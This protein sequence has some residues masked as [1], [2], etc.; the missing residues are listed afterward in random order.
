[1]PGETDQAVGFL[2]EFKNEASADLQQAVTDFSKATEALE[3]AVDAAQAAF[4]FLEESTAKLTQ[5]LE[6]AIG[7]VT[8]KAHELKTALEHIPGAEIEAPDFDPI[9]EALDTFGD[10]I[11]QPPDIGLSDAL[12]DL[13]EAE[14]KLPFED[15]YEEFF[16]APE[17][18]VPPDPTPIPQG[19]G[20]EPLPEK[21]FDDRFQLPVLS[22]MD[23][24]LDSIADK[25]RKEVTPELSKFGEAGRAAAEAIGKDSVAAYQNLMGEAKQFALENRRALEES[26]DVRDIWTKFWESNEADLRKVQD[27]LS[28][29]DK[30]DIQPFVQGLVDQLGDAALSEAFWGPLRNNKN[31]DREFFTDLRKQF[32]KEKEVY[33]TWWDRLSDSAKEKFWPEFQKQGEKAFDAIGGGLGSKLKALFESPLGQITSAIQLSKMLDRVLSPVLDMLG[34]VVGR[35]LVPVFEV[36]TI[37]MQ[38]LGPV[39][40]E[41]NTAMRPFYEALT[42]V[43]RVLIRSLLPLIHLFAD[44]LQAITPLIVI[45]LNVVTDVLT[46]IISLATAVTSVLVTAFEGMLRVVGTTLT[47]LR[48]VLS[49]VVWLFRTLFEVAS[50]VSV[51]LEY[52]AWVIGVVLLPPLIEL[53]VAALP[54]LIVN[55][56]SWVS[57]TLAA[58]TVSTAWAANLWSAAAAFWTGLI[59]SLGAAAAATWAFTAALL[60]NPLTWI[61]L[62][63]AAAVGV[64]AYA[65]SQIEAVVDW[66][67]DLGSTILGV[68]SGPLN[69]LITTLG[70]VYDLMVS[71]FGSSE[72]SESTFSLG[73]ITDWFTWIYDWVVGW[74]NFLPWWVKWLL[75]IDTESQAEQE[76]A[77]IVQTGQVI[78]TTELTAEESQQAWFRSVAEVEQEP[79]P[80]SPGEMDPE[81]AK[82]FEGLFSDSFV[83]PGAAL[84]TTLSEAIGSLV[85]LPT[86]TDGLATEAV[87]EAEQA[88][89]KPQPIMIPP[90]RAEVAKV[91][92]K[93]IEKEIDARIDTGGVANPIIA[94][95]EEQTRA[96]ERAIGGINTQELNLD[97]SDLKDIAE[98]S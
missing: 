33:Q 87:S 65:F 61:V 27:M 36:F 1:M 56:W 69:I 13:N 46:A 10:K 35:L 49:P 54:T 89:A 30:K 14:I 17:T 66:F 5:S 70:W 98:F 51:P 72:E 45:V 58:N 8:Q 23:V 83:D 55:V 50:L 4:I 78:D 22:D 43:G 81:T 3:R 62:A 75:G 40:A 63:V 26:D 39:I 60:A 52:V 7:G 79:Q 20:R 94:A 19:P 76:E 2:L 90:K 86:S 32:F 38:E 16:D 91:V 31:V 80:L 59:P 15:V 37:L 41:I 29:A 95:L 11:A 92:I 47:A 53:G 9:E 57:A 21:P 42:D 6:G 67:A 84:V 82:T 64:L 44:L 34:E 85:N 93:D 73:W 48:W 74:V 96:L 18:I 28:V 88:A 25:L 97:L 77:Q 68:V 71:I 12:D 24:A